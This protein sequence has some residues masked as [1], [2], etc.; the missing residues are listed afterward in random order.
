MLMV[1]GALRLANVF[2]TLLANLMQVL[3]STKN[4]STQTQTS[5]IVSALTL[6][7]SQRTACRPNCSIRKLVLA[8]VLRFLAHHSSSKT[9]HPV[10]ANAIQMPNS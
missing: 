6:M 8:S 9:M 2:A 5:A 4:F 10:N 7:V 3:A 1:D